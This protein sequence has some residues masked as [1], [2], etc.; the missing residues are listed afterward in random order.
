[1][2]SKE[3]DR[4]RDKLSLNLV[5]RQII[6]GSL[7]GDGYLYPTVSK[8]YAYFRIAHGPKQKDYVWWKYNYFKNWVLTSPHYQ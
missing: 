6:I 7:L 8:K 3:I 4:L 2:F 5:Q 1:M